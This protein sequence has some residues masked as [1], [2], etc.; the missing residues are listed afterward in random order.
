MKLERI[1]CKH[2]VHAW[3]LAVSD[4]CLVGCTGKRAVIL[5]RAYQ[6]L[7]KIEGLDYVYAA[8]VSPDEGEVLLVSNENK[9]YVADLATGE[10]RKVL[11]RAPYHYNLEGRGCW[12]HDGKRL[13]LL[14]TNA[15]TLNSALRIYDAADLTRYEDLLT[16]RY[17][18]LRIHRLGDGKSYLLIGNSR[19]DGQTCLIYY[20][21][22]SFVHRPLPET[23]TLVVLG[24]D[25]D[26]ETGAVTLYTPRGCYKYTAEGEMVETLP[27]PAAKEM[28]TSF[29][30]VFSKMYAD[31][32][33]KMEHIRMVCDDLGLENVK[34][35]D[36][37]TKYSRRGDYFCITSKSGFYMVDARTAETLAYLPEEYG[38][39]NF[40]WVEPDVIALATWSGVKL[41][42]LIEN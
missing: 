24:S 7:R 22:V 29:S 40:E 9:F 13:L 8:D 42:R 21:G 33:E 25:V 3:D 18:L 5:D 2:L 14:V 17:Q 26:P 23:E 12:S 31:D 37:I 28:R 27:H 30:D 36:M 4:S 39:Q 35:P 41:Y 19:P 15:K 11:V 38:V 20:D 32:P 1:K 16:E 10:K 6:L 34:T